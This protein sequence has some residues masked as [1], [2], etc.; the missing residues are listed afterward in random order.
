MTLK[1][2]DAGN[3]DNRPAAEKYACKKRLP[4]LLLFLLGSL[5]ADLRGEFFLIFASLALVSFCNSFRAN[6]ELL[7]ERRQ[8][9][10]RSL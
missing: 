5:R 2:C 10:L 6:P 4:R 3:N 9:S 7:T 1:A 8:Q